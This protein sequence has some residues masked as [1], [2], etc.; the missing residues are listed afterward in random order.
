MP[1]RHR[2]VIGR[3]PLRDSPERHCQPFRES[4]LATPE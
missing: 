4:V 3:G 1:A 2:A